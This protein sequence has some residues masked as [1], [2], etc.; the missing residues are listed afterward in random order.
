[1]FV[2]DSW[3]LTMSE[4]AQL[5]SSKRTVALVDVDGTVALMG[6]GEEGRRKFYDWDRV[7][8]DDPNWPII[9]LVRTLQ[10]AGFYIIFISG[11]DEVCRSKTEEWLRAKVI[12]AKHIPLLMRAHKD[13]RPD[14][15]VKLELYRY[16]IEPFYHVSYVLDDRDQVVKMW[17]ELGL[18][19]LQVA[20]G[21]F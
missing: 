13:N 16:Y 21:A 14:A 10:A 8:E 18:T 1:M 5:D 7:D 20:D 2:G 9:L 15:T 6:K 4:E 19:V 3:R 17:R 12:P 11:R